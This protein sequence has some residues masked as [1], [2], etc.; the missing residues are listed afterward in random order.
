MKKCALMCLLTS[1]LNC[2]VLIF[3]L[4]AMSCSLAVEIKEYVSAKKWI[5]ISDSLFHYIMKQETRI[6][7]LIELRNLFMQ[8]KQAVL[9][10]NSLP[11]RWNSQNKNYGK[12]WIINL[13]L[14]KGYLSSKWTNDA[15]CTSSGEFP[16]R[17][18][19][20][21]KKCTSTRKAIS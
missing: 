19:Q 2:T 11:T 16:T 20:Q 12:Q 7:L 1:L 5:G 6:I 8:E 3:L 18:G 21:G 13:N 14:L 15:F 9:Y 17:G 10:L 4:H